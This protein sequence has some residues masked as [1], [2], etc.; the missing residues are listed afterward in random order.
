MGFFKSI[1]LLQFFLWFSFVNAAPTYQQMAKDFLFEIV[2]VAKFSKSQQGNITAESQTKVKSLSQ[3]IDYTALAKK[4]LGARWAKYKEQERKDF[5]ATLQTLLEEV[6]YPKAK[7]INVD[8]EDLKF[9][10]V[11]GKPTQVK[12][13]AE[14]EREKKGEMVS[15]SLD[16]VMVYD[17]KSKKL[18]DAIIDGE[19]VS[20]N[21]KRQFDEALKKKTFAQIIEQMKKRV[22]DAKVANN[23]L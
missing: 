12:A 4:S 1:A 9:E 13:T 14:V 21:L 17:A 15:Q 23:P 16:I 8:N 18:V 3:K 11:K 20:S 2:E 5:L 6:V 10:I 19:Q 22:S 7:N